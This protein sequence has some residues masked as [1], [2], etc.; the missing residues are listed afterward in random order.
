VGE[1][2]VIACVSCFGAARGLGGP[3]CLCRAVPAW[4]DRFAIM[5]VCG[6]SWAPGVVFIIFREE[7]FNMLAVEIPIVHLV[8]P[9]VSCE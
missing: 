4:W 7:F 6:P 5:G 2:F 3:L 9:T 8:E 1:D